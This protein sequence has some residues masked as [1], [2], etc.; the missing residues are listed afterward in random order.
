MQSTQAHTHDPPPWTPA[1]L[2]ACLPGCLTDLS[3]TTTGLSLLVANMSPFQIMSAEKTIMARFSD[4]ASSIR[5]LRKSFFSSFT[6]V[7]RVWASVGEWGGMDGKSWAVDSRRPV[8]DVWE[9][10]PSVDSID[11][12][13]D[14]PIKITINQLTCPVT[15][16][17]ILLLAPPLICSLW[18]WGTKRGKSVVVMSR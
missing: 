7:S 12:A 16:S 9:L 11:R 2:A 5:G 14:R 6:C 15:I 1:C 13:I 8:V 17:S 10:G 4:C 3:T 18:G